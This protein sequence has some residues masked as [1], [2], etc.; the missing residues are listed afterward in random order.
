VAVLGCAAL[1]LGPELGG[2]AAAVDL[3]GAALAA[4]A[5]LSYAAYALIGGKLIARG[6]P[7]SAV[8]GAMFGGAVLLVLSVLLGS[9]P[10]RLLTR[11]GVLVAAHL[12]LVTTFLAY[13]LFGYGLRHTTAQVATTLTLAEPTVAAVL[14]VTVLGERLPSASWCG[15]AVLAADLAFLSLPPRT[16]RQRR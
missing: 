3:L 12:A 6:H 14:G 16:G 2:G 7:S 9:D 4:L 15:M 13:R 11:R 8:M 10:H 5:G 1:V